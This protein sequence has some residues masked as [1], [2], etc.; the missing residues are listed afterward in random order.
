MSVSKR[1]LEITTNFEKLSPDEAE[2]RGRQLRRKLLDLLKPVE[3]RE[4]TRVIE[5]GSTDQGLNNTHSE[6]HAH[7]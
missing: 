7:D 2:E 4:K 5:L 3:E 1:Y 6:E